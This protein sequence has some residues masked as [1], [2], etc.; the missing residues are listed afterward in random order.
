MRSLIDLFRQR[1]GSLL[2]ADLHPT[3]RLKLLTPFR[4]PLLISRHRAGLIVDRVR[5]FALLFALLTPLWG[6]VDMLAF[7]FP[8]WCQLLA[9]RLLVC[10]AFLS[11]LLFYREHGR[12][13][14]AYLSLI[15][16]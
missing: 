16:I 14:D 12:M 5:L 1:L 11:L 2:P 15:H 6:I 8:L 9:L 7:P 13:A 4:H 10:A 3:E